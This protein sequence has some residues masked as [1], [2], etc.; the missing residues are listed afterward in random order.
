MRRNREAER[1]SE[2]KKAFTHSNLTPSSSNFPQT[3]QPTANSA[4]QTPELSHCAL[5]DSSY[6]RH[7][8]FATATVNRTTQ[9]VSTHEH[10]HSK[11]KSATATLSARSILTTV[12]FPS[13]LI[14]DGAAADSKWRTTTT[15]IPQRWQRVTVQRSNSSAEHLVA[16][17][18]HTDGTQP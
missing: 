18:V 15:R 4:F 13:T 11:T 16:V 12:Y 8:H 10:G 2:K 5:T 3:T 7:T 17:E 9:M 6:A 1:Q 14:A